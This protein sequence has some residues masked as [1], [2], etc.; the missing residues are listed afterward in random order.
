M[1]DLKVTETQF[2]PLNDEETGELTEWSANI[3]INDSWMIQ[4][5]TDG[6]YS[7]PHA[8]LAAWN[9]D[10]KQ[11]AAS[12]KYDAAELAKELKLEELLVARYFEEVK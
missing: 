10:E 5:G 8:A 3:A 11:Q 1:T 12:E 7:I 6:A 4:R 2:F 9:D